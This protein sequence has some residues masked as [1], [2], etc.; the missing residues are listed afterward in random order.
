MRKIIKFLFIFLV[1][2]VIVAALYM[3]F[4][5]AFGG[6]PTKEQKEYYSQFDNYA[7]GK[8]VNTYKPKKPNPGGHYRVAERSERIPPEPLPA[9]EVDWEKINSG[10]DSLTWFGHSAFLLSIDNKKL[11]V[12]PMLGPNSSPVS[13][14]KIKRFNGDLLRLIDEMPPIDAVLLTHDHYDHLDY[15]SMKKIKDKTRRFFVP[16]GVGA[17]L[18]RWG[19]PREQIT[20]LNWWQETEFDG[21]TLALTP[22]I[23]FSGRNLFN[24]NSTLWGGWAVFGKNARLYISGDGGYGDHFKEIGEKYGPFD[25]ALIEGAQ[26]DERWPHSHMIPEQSV[27]A[28]MDVKGETMMLMHWGAF[29]LSRHAWD[30][31]IERALKEAE[32]RQVR[33]IT[34]KIGETVV[35]KT[36]GG[37][38]QETWWR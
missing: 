5:P 36:L 9:A 30:E 20:E 35:L 12:D 1:V 8:F 21:L 16:L 22:S 7:D 18:V 14:V 27:Q 11:L 31:P 26:Y 17:H 32:K 4:A 29:T 10:E 19:V 13:F 24:R 34:P 38:K 23:H 6:N 33:L 25:L 28:H 2:F 15:R 37:K 3:N